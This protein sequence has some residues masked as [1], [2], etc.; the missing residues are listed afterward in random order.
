[1]NTVL[2]IASSCLSSV[3]VSRLQHGKLEMEIVLN[4]TL[5][6]GVAIGTCSDLSNNP[7]ISMLIGFLA[8]VLSAYGFAV[9]G[10]ALK[11]KIK[12]HDTCGVHNLHGMPGVFSAICGAILMATNPYPDVIGEG[13]TAGNQ[14]VIQILVLLITLGISISG[15]LIS[16]FIV[17]KV[18]TGPTA[19]EMFDDE[20]H[21]E[22]AEQE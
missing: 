16:G 17:S 7:A 21:F 3:A 4:S 11:E 13:R 8:G 12:L 18:V 14:A 2:A 22:G 9:I 15:G 10:P 19:E 6:G 1:M 5:A 20:P